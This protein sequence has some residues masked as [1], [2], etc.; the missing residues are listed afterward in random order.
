MILCALAWSGEV[1]GETGYKTETQDGSFS[2]SGG[3]M[4]N[5][6]KGTL[7][8]ETTITTDFYDAG[9]K[10]TVTFSLSGGSN[11]GNNIEIDG[12]TTYTLSWSIS[13]NFTMEMTAFSLEGRSAA[14]TTWNRPTYT[15]TAGGKSSSSECYAAAGSWK[16]A[17]LSGFSVSGTSGSLTITTDRTK[18]AIFYIHSLSFT[19]TVSHQELIL[20]DLNTA[21]TNATNLQNSLSNTTLKGY[22]TTAISNANTFKESCRFPSY[23]GNVE[24]SDVD[25]ATAK[26][27]AVK[28][29]VT[30]LNTALSYERTSVPDAVYN[31]LRQYYGNTPVD[32]NTK[33]ATDLT[34]TYTKNLNAAITLAENT[35]AAYATAISH[36]NAAVTENTT[37]HNSN[38]TIATEI[39]NA[40]NDLEASTTVEAITTAQN[41]FIAIKAKL[42]AITA[43]NTVKAT[44]A[45]YEKDNIPDA[46]HVLLHQYD[47]DNPYDDYATADVVNA[48]KSKLKEA[49]AAAKATTTPYLTAKN[50]T[51]P[52]KQL[53]SDNNNP[54]GIADEDIDDAYDALELATTTQMINNAIALV[55]NF[56]S[57]KF[58]GATSIA[59]GGSIT[60]PASADSKR[61][62]SYLVP[63]GTTIMNIDDNSKTLNAVA[64]G[65]VTV[66]ATTCST[67][68]GYYKCDKTQE[69]EILPVFYFSV[70]AQV[71]TGGGGSVS[72]EGYQPI[73][74]GTAYNTPS[75]SLNLKFKATPD[76]GYVFLG[77]G[78]TAG[79]TSYEPGGGETYELQLTNDV[80]GQENE[81][82]KTLYA[83]FA[84]QFF[85]SATVEKNREGGVATA[86][87][88][89]TNITGSPGDESASTIASFSASATKDSYV[90]MGWKASLDANSYVSDENPYF[91]SLNNSNPGSA[92]EVNKT[93]YAIFAPIYNFSATAEIGSIAGGTA[94]VTGYD[95]S[96]E[97]APDAEE[98]TT[99]ATFTA[100]AASD[101]KFVGWSKTEDGDI[102]STENPYYPNL[103]NENPGTTERLALYAIFKLSRIHLYSDTEPDYQAGEYDEVQLHR[104]F[105]KGYSTIALPF[106]TTLY[107]L[108]GQQSAEDWVA[109]LSVVTYTAA[110]N[111]YT[112]YFKKT[113]NGEDADGG[114]ILANRPYVLHLSKAVVNPVW[115]NQAVSAPSTSYVV[116][117]EKGYRNNDNDKYSAWKMRANY[118]PGESMNGRYGIV[119]NAHLADDP[120]PEHPGESEKTRFP[121]GCLKLGGNGST[122]NAFMAYIEGPTSAPVKAAYLDDDDNADGLLELLTGESIDSSSESVYDLQGR[123]L[124]KAQRGLNI[125]RGADGV[126]RK[127]MNN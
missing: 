125:I 42:E 61:S 75:A 66:T 109:Q 49:I 56:D 123:K 36:Y 62:I 25:N 27:N 89:D 40:K 106:N 55:K 127:V 116:Q 32:P 70:D 15:I 120:D 6:C 112:L 117:A 118:E 81:V 30:A 41:K 95:T 45:S 67:G 86:F 83:I 38:S 5:I 8:N 115:E 65:K 39:Q 78:T 110:D 58:S 24:P 21:I 63:N 53:Q 84:P 101:Y 57:I 11:S 108:T 126:V 73:V 9:T 92:N 99:T 107:E 69:Y 90:F 119:N 19:Y 98:E 111:G 50:T 68:D 3:T 64:P 43:F 96:I 104:S 20:T 13:S 59:M 14:G 77:W 100:T 105:N 88:V 122:L 52:A 94:T 97:G 37:N 47:N 48:K 26:L 17:S 76:D 87:V 10:A 114:I 34:N 74:T 121:D 71:G 46:V 51:L 1:W 7:K 79:A 33:T 16:T 60:N 124:P 103:T 72:L 18:A 22:M 93:L 2:T 29:Y 91:V 82:S 113:G 4:C 54:S 35:K 102:V 85:F 12:S 80:Y 44:A 23:I 28:D 31:K